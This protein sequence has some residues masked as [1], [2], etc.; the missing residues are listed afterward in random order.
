MSTDVIAPDDGSLAT[1]P[2]RG[3]LTVDRAQA[4]L[5]RVLQRRIRLVDR[6]NG[7][8]I[9][10]VREPNPSAKATD[11]KVCP[12]D[13]PGIQMIFH[14]GKMLKEA[15]EIEDPY[16]RINAQAGITKQLAALCDRFEDQNSKIVAEV[17]KFIEMERNKGELTDE[18]LA[19]LA[20]QA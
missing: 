2:K 3:T 17:Q 1:T 14:L 11:G 8:S 5:D 9:P 16:N 6:Y 19:K 20:E 15:T 18:D 10:G 13:P 7:L 12:G 4:L